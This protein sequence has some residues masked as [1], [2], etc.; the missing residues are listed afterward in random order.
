MFRK[1]QKK[2][3]KIAQCEDDEDVVMPVK[4]ELPKKRGISSTELCSIGGGEANEEIVCKKFVK[5]KSGVEKIREKNWERHVEKVMSGEKGDE[6]V[7]PEK[8]LPDNKR[9]TEGAER[10][11]WLA[12]LVEVP[13]SV[14]HKIDN[15]E[16]TEAATRK[17]IRGEGGYCSRFNHLH[18]FEYETFTQNMT[19]TRNNE[20]EIERIE[21]SMTL[22]GKKYKLDKQARIKMNEKYE[23]AWR[24]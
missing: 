15:I 19:K 18:Q 1:V 12:G 21:K 9:I 10:S 3:M 5:E 24:T 4:I 2:G 23:N 8:Y 6:F 7:I 20:K 14:E 22:R 11:L 13:L 16:A 17:A